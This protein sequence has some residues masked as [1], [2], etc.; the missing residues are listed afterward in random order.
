[1]QTTESSSDRGF[2]RAML[3]GLVGFL[4]FIMAWMA[5]SGGVPPPEAEGRPLFSSLA[6]AVVTGL[7]VKGRRWAWARIVALFALT[8]AAMLVVTV[9]PKINGVGR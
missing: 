5:V 3:C 9:L 1:M 2:R 6:P 8:A 4:A 7:V